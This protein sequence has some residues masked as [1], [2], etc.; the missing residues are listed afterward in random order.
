MRRWLSNQLSD[1]PGVEVLPSD[2]NFVSFCPGK[3][4]EAIWRNLAEAG[5][6]VSWSAAFRSRRLP[7]S[8]RGS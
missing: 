8:H 5:I 6:A 7:K 1:I 2:T 3:P 4:A